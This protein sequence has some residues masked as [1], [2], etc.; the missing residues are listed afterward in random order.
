MEPPRIALPIM[1]LLLA[2]GLALTE[3]FALLPGMVAAYAGSWWVLGLDRT[4]RPGS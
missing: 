2:G 3:S 1:G 4:A